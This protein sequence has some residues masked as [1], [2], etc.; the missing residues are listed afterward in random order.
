M[1]VFLYTRYTLGRLCT[2]KRKEAPPNTCTLFDLRSSCMFRGWCVH[3]KM[4]IC[5]RYRCPIHSFV[6]IQSKINTT[7]ELGYALLCEY[8]FFP[9]CVQ[10]RQMTTERKNFDTKT[11]TCTLSDKQ[12][13]WNVNAIGAMSVWAKEKARA[14]SWK[15]ICEIFSR[16]T[17]QFFCCVRV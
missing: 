5:T 15:K 12:A 16:F 1:Y 9:S 11:N 13:T 7:T 6:R 17:L 2:V 14:G 3:R 4:M 10:Y 8:I